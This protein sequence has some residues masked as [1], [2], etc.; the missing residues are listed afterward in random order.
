MGL[1]ELFR[2]TGRVAV[3]Y[4]EA[5][6]GI[7]AVSGSADN[8]ARSLGAL[9]VNADETQTSIHGLG[10]E[11]ERTRESTE[12]LGE[13]TERTGEET[14]NTNEGF[15][16]W[17]ATLANLASSVIQKA[18]SKITELAK[19]IVGL[20]KD[21]TATMSEVKAI[22]GASD[23]DFQKLTDTAREFGSKTVFS[24]TEA[25]EALKYMS[26]AGW[27]AEQSSAALGG[28]LD[29]AAASGMGLGEASDMVTD[30][31][32]AFGMEAQESAYFADMLAY[33]QANSNTTAS[34][35]GEA[36]GNCGATLHAAGQDIETVTS[37]LEAMANQGLKGSEA[38]TALNATMRDITNSMNTVKGKTDLAKLAQ[39]EFVS[40]TGDLNDL[41]GRNYITMGKTLIPVSDA[42]GNFRD[43]T[44][45]LTDV[46]KAT[47]GMGDA[48]KAAAMS[49]TFT[50]YS[51]KGVNLVLNEG[52]DQVSKYEKE[53]RK[54]DG[55]AS[56]M[57]STMNDN[58]KGDLAGMNSAL[59]ELKLKI[60]DGLEGPLRSAAQFITTK[61]V[62]AL[63]ALMQNFDKIAP[64]ILIAATAIGTFLIVAN[65]GSILT[66]FTNGIGLVTKAFTTLNTTLLANPIALVIAA[67][68]ALVAAFIYLWNNCEGFRNFWINLWD[69][70]KKYAGI[71]G[72]ALV[73][74]INSIIN[75]WANVNLSIAETWEKIK[76]FL[77]TAKKVLN[78][79]VNDIIQYWVNVCLKIVEKSLEIKKF[80]KSIPKW[81]NEKIIQPITA[82][83]S[84]L[85][86]SITNKAKE[87]WENIKK[88]FGKVG[89]FFS[90]IWDTFKSKFSSI[91]T[92]VGN[93]IGGAFK[94]AI[95]SVLETIERT[96]NFI[97]DK[98]NPVLQTITDWT[99]VSLPFM[100]VI[101][102]PRLAKG[103]VVNSKTVAEIGEDGTEAVVPLEKNTE[104]TSKV[105]ELIN[106]KSNNTDIV[107]KL[108]ELISIA[109]R[110]RPINLTLPIENFNNTAQ[111]SLDDIS[112]LIKT[113]LYD[114]I[115]EDKMA[116]C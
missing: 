22:S 70:I 13:E 69:N 95:N 17:K 38:G 58:L 107:S 103:G 37:F 114:F 72:E 87:T 1:L 96:L 4:S 67:V 7:E 82:F 24:A 44:D 116:R 5:Q 86:D 91:G 9:T 59:E 108:D 78:D 74:L 12:G 8:T 75:F 89:D 98:V 34:Q 39:D 48:E 90:G 111:S 80:F 93:A 109:E 92:A 115:R 19:E 102:L 94:K 42:S 76:N 27:D 112:N 110:I 81:F 63:T 106:S 35:L 101:S 52:I 64:P 79:F 65:A 49:N 29:L 6:R 105:A 88:A 84:S 2:I 62:P 66:A 32:S 61:V 85:W 83:F 55:S 73:E 50:S 3:E 71:A 113:T 28:V 100:P 15:T 20:G 97:P 54:A 10:T 45:I 40:S 43:L 46:S 14:E 99:G 53:L 31:L 11:T 36:Y 57:A 68:A 47:D 21:F 26:L 16:T 23:E 33:A 51:I 30:Y 104:W 41:L 18:I 25:A 56:N 60:Y 77:K